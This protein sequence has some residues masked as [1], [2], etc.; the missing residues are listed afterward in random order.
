M[1]TLIEQAPDNTLLPVGM[2]LIFTVSN[3]TVVANQLSVKFI[4]VVHMS[5]DVQ[6][7]I[8]TNTHKIGT[9]KTTPNNHGVGIF[10][11]RQVCETEVAADNMEKAATTDNPPVAAKFK[12]LD[13][14]P[15][16][17]P[18][19]IHLIDKFTG[20]TNFM[21][22]LVIRF[23]T[24]YIDSS[25][26]LQT[27]DFTNTRDYKIFNGYLN[28]SDTLSWTNNNISFNANNFQLSNSSKSFVSNMPTIQYANKEDYGVFTAITGQTAFNSIEFTY[29]N[30][31]GGVIASEEIVEDAANGLPTYWTGNMGW[32]GIYIGAFPANLRGW[33]STFTSNLD[34][35]YYYTIQAF[36]HSSV[37]SSQL[38][39][40]YINCPTLKGYEP[41]RL[42]WL[43]KW[44]GWDYYTFTQKSISSKSK[45]ETTYFQLHGN[46]NSPVYEFSG[47]RGG[48]K[49][50]R[51]NTTENIRIN[52]DYVKEDVSSWFEELV[53]SPEVYQ[54]K[55]Y[56]EDYANSA[57]NE[58]VIPVTIKTKKFTKK[59]IANDKL[60]QYE[61]EI[62]KTRFERTQSI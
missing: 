5:P 22:W 36:N 21:K 23:K 19:P 11:L 2:D 30:D 39:S 24:E 1:P 18:I 48:K 51:V 26:V 25:G 52:S 45:K 58:Y 9:F 41:I 14:E 32:R 29:Y 57:L 3:A 46:Y 20:Q 34:D 6:P 7:D 53:N 13:G 62:E 40:I 12:E 33:S 61:F 31:A 35:I 37:A 54:L 17:A 10:N 4:A 28:Y 56:K 44:G 8:S 49:T 38:Y 47:H 16:Q 60:I 55:G 43:N 15:T 59:T 27:V 42:A 50:F